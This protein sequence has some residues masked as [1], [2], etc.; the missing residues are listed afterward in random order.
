MSNNTN[1][2]RSNE[3]GKRR[4]SPAVVAAALRE[5]DRARS[6]VIE[7]IDLTELLEEAVEA[8]RHR[9]FERRI[10]IACCVLDD[11]AVLGSEREIATRLHTMLSAVIE[12]AAPG[13]RMEC[14]AVAERS[15][16]VVRIRFMRAAKHPK[17]D[18][19]EIVGGEIVACWPRIEDL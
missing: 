5:L 6:D 16:V 19:A 14:N 4:Q 9:A 7:I 13:T 10:R 2:E 18:S 11:L 1:I 12:T 17:G 3:A 15:G 8:H